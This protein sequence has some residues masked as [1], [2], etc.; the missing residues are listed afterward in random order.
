MEDI[1]T[2]LVS[3]HNQY[4]EYKNSVYTER[5]NQML[6]N[7]MGHYLSQLHGNIQPRYSPNPLVR[8]GLLIYLHIN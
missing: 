1:S 5:I 3:L 7:N 8:G 2:R 6:Q 4:L